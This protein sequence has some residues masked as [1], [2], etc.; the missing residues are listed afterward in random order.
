MSRFGVGEE[1]VRRGVYLQNLSRR[2]VL[3]E[4]L[5]NRANVYWDRGDPERAA[6][7]L[8]RVTRVSHGFSFDW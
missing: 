1:L 6:R 5:N 7:D 3:S 8:D 2:E 4:V